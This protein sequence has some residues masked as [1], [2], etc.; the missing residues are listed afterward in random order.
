[1]EWLR[2]S[3]AYKLQRLMLSKDAGGAL[4]SAALG[5]KWKEV[6]G[7]IPHQTTPNADGNEEP[8]DMEDDV[9]DDDD[10]SD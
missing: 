4:F 2:E 9:D 8:D 1:M 5:E 6:F 7:D 10:D 3:V